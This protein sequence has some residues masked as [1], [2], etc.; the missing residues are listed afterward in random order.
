MPLKLVKVLF[1]LRNMP[2][3]NVSWQLMYNGTSYMDHNVM[4]HYG[5][6]TKTRKT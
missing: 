5:G 2:Y 3:L 1:E 4:V 6:K